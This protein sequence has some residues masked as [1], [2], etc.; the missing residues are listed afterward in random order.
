MII[1]NHR[2]ILTHIDTFSGQVTE[3][4]S[5]ARQLSASLVTTTDH[6]HYELWI[7]CIRS[8]HEQTWKKN[9]EKSKNLHNA[10]L[11]VD[12]SC[13]EQQFI[14]SCFP[15]QNGVYLRG[16][17]SII[18]SLCIK[19]WF[20]V[21]KNLGT[22]ASCSAQHQ[23]KQSSCIVIGLFHVK[24]TQQILG[25]F[26]FTENFFASFSL[27]SSEKNHCHFDLLH[28]GGG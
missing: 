6:K 10:L 8:W 17:L 22:L 23:M 4:F 28:G 26:D 19:W 21:P 1:Q 5:I 20:F 15:F 14:I 24:T 12:A 7:E 2:T 16:S 9:R 27:W 3:I 18:I 13:D 11:D 25:S